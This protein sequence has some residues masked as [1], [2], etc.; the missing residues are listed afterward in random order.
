MPHLVVYHQQCPVCGR[1]L[2][3]GVKLLGHRVYCQHCGG[4]FI[5]HHEAAGEA[6]GPSV[7]DKAA[8]LIER[9]ALVLGQ[10]GCDDDAA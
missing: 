7:A 8:E 1:Q 2:E 10:A 9:A 6:G 3:I 4:G 5:A